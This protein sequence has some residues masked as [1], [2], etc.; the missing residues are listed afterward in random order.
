MHA[1]LPIDPDQRDEA[2]ELIQETAEQ[3]RNDEGTLEF[4]AST[5]VD[6]P[7]RVTFFEC[8]ED[9]AAIEQHRQTDHY[10]EFGRSIQEYLTGK[11]EITRYDVDSMTDIEV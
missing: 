1:V 3:Y 9:E 10:K 2:L 11:P 6:D 5:N 8:Y 7:N 4:Q